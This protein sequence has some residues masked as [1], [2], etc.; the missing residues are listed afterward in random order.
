[1]GS[2]AGFPT[3]VPGW[4]QRDGDATVRERDGLFAN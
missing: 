4:L 2:L 1:M 3:A